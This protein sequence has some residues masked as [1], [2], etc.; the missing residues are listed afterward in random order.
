[1][2]SRE[3]AAPPFDLEAIPPPVLAV[4]DALAAGGHRALLVGGCIRDLL[5]GREPLEFDV[6]TTAAPATLLALFPRGVPIGVRYA[7]VMVPTESGPVDVTRFRGG[8]RIEDDLAHRDFTANAVAYDPRTG[9]LVDPFDGRGD[10]AARR[11]RPVGSAEERFAEDPLRAV[12]AA[13]LVASLDFEADPA[14]EAAM[15]GARQGLRGVARERVRRELSAMF[16][17][18][19]AA[20]GLT[21]L[22]RGGLE[23]DLAP[24][25]APDAVAILD[26]LPCDLGLRLAAWLRGARAGAILRRCRFPRRTGER[27]Q[28]LLRNH[29]ID[30]DVDPS[31]D[32]AV[33]RL[34]RRVGEEEL[35]PL[36]A[37]RRAELRHGDEARRD[38][39]AELRKRLDD[40]EQAIE[41]VRRA[42]ALALRRFDLAIDGERVM[43][44]LGCGPGPI[45]GRALS[46]LTDRVVEDP[47]LNA[48]DALEQR[49]RA[50]AA[51]QPGEAPG[52]DRS[53]A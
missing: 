45:V 34:I 41:R 12:R 25:A 32:A 14:V 8:A 51:R 10:I 13:R 36:L 3:P 52:R 2:A 35:A 26:A 43:E 48:P 46:Y 9:E 22:R 6:A 15:P 23:S 24:G 27:V 21:L 16:V 5:R 17:A 50:W 28:H 19:R 42:G 37:L 7:T 4:V 47:S 44:L 11:L 18:P 30:A 38:D 40:V 1:M 39:A 33:R 53:G 31:R 29:P 20:R 49:L